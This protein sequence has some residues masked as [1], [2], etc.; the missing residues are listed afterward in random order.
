MRQTEGL[1]A[2]GH[3]LVRNFGNLVPVAVEEEEESLPLDE[4]VDRLDA[5]LG[6][7]G[8][9]VEEARDYPGARGILEEFHL[10]VEESEHLA[11][12]L[13][14]EISLEFVA[15]GVFVSGTTLELRKLWLIEGCQRKGGSLWIG[16]VGLQ[17]DSK[18]DQPTRHAWV[19]LGR[20]EAHGVG[21]PNNL[22]RILIL[23][24]Y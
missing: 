5:L 14:R 2:S 17:S 15:H 22:L 18:I 4:R 10:L 24:R 13:V 21:E 7:E 1:G 8:E 11:P 23:V 20:L 3:R 9:V 6:E 16:E 19:G 12:N